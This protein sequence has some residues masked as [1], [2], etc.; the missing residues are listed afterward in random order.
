MAIQRFTVLALWIFSWCGPL[1]LV[2]AQ[3]A[4]TPIYR[5]GATEKKEEHKRIIEQMLRLS[6]EGKLISKQEIDK[7]T[8]APQRQVVEL[9]SVRKQEMN[10]ED[11]AA[12]ARASNLRVG[13]CYKCPRCD[14]WHLNLAGGY[15]IAE[16]VIV[17]CDH[18]LKTK[19]KMRDGYLVVVD[20]DG[21]VAGA[22]AV[23]ASNEMMDAA[24]IKVV[25]AKF[26]PV[27]LNHDV[28]QGAAS[29]CFSHP[30]SQQGY[31]SSGIVNRFFWND[32]YRDEKEDSLDALRHLRVNFSNDWAPGSSGSP[33]F[34][35]AGNVV[36]HVSTISGLS[37]GKTNG[38][39]ITI[40]TGTPARSVEALV[41][42][43]REPAA[44]AE[45]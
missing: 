40:H 21:N 8:L 27:P 7:Q 38:P 10:T 28:R 44:Q 36:G 16:D 45:K 15:A 29:Y 41:R 43:M 1:P 17:T 22:V 5:Q 19:T 12:L 34:D 42:A 2:W 37:T 39:M 9:Q 18:V 3:S 23:L 26:A 25:G 30:L 4:D 24:I 35:Q 14:D 11:V 31:F 33:L 13:Y 32:S 6:G 20:H